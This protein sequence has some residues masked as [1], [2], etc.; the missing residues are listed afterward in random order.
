M[1]VVPWFATRYSRLLARLQSRRLHHGLLL[2]GPPGIGKYQFARLLAKSALCKALTP[3]G[4]CSACQSCLLFDAGNHPDMAELVSD[5]QLGVDAIRGGIA[6]LHATAQ[7]NGNKVLVIPQAHRMTEPA[8]NALLKTLEEPTDNTFLVLITDRPQQLLATIV[9]RCEKHVLP[10]PDTE[11][12][13]GWLREQGV[14]DATP[15]LLHAYGAAPFTLLQ[16]L[17]EETGIA[18]R[19]FRE[20]LDTLLAGGNDAVTLATQW[21]DSAPSIVGWLQQYAHEQCVQY[22]NASSFSLFEACTQANRMLQNPGVNKVMILSC[23]LA[24]IKQSV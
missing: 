20:G 22:P 8:A 2:T 14:D 13:L 16:A 9:S 21:Q 19:T 17:R 1:S 24:E 6:K 4:Y 12:A 5:K 11:Q 23:L 7:L 10:P 3:Q 15:A 18:Y